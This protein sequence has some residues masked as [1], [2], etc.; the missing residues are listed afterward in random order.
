M[1]FRNCL[2]KIAECL[3]SD[4]L[5]ALKFL[6]LDHIAHKKQ[7]P[8][9]DALVLF[10]VLQEKGLLEE[11]N[12]SFLKE[13]LFLIKRLDL[14]ANFLNSSKEE[15]VRELQVLDK[16]QVSP[17]RVMLFQLSEDVSTMELKSFKFFLNKEIPKC[18]L[19]DDNS[20]LLDIFVEMEKRL[21]LTENNLDI[22]KLICE[23]VN[24]SLLEKIEGYEN[25]SRE[26]RMSLEARTDSPVSFLDG[27]SHFRMQEMWDSLQEQCSH[28]Q[29]SDRIYQMKSKPRGYCLIFNNNDFSKARKDIPKLHK[30]KDR[31][32]TNYDEEALTETFKELHF[33]VVPYRDC[34]ASKIHDVL[35]SYQSMD[36]K[37]KDCFVCCILS[38]GDK[39][40]IY[41]TDG[42]EAS[43]YE[44]TSYF[45]GSKCPSLA[46]KPKIFFIQACQGDNYQKAVLVE[47]DLE[48]KDSFLDV[49]SSQKNYIPDEADF[50]L[51]M[52]TVKNCV[53]YR[54]PT[55]GTWYIQS[56]C[57]SLRER[58]PQ[59]DDI[60]SILTGVNYDV[61]NKD[62][63]KNMG[64]Q[65][66]QPTFTLRKK[67]FFPPN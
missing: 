61:S 23:Q 4:E 29:V 38:H 50:L 64:K 37:N 13:L 65:M 24:K 33:E 11:G 51:G 52:A 27:E 32:G 20:S 2:Y 58:C 6:C 18:K 3:V 41:G 7:E 35:G 25:S 42:K 54:D 46:G 15:M 49:D 43:I 56:L 9:N 17:Y 30:M 5:A 21:L 66:P 44:L 63:R 31:K 36:H 12:L 40:I 22:L 55:Q 28:S 39:G 8:I 10:E 67:L 19:N 57:Q 16:A 47:T 62:D 53:S 48:E 60:L 14:L 1:D 59:G 45:T 26:R 34:T